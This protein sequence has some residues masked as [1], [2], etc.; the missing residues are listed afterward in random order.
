MTNKR[1][2]RPFVYDEEELRA[3][4]KR[5]DKWVE[6]DKNV[7]FGCFFEKEK[8]TQEH[9]MARGDEYDF[10]RESVEKAR[11]IQQARL[12]N[13]ALHK[14]LSDGMAK[15]CLINNHGWTEKTQISGDKANP[16]AIVLDE[17]DGSTKSLTE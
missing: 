1:M 17:I 12:I 10:I 11:G 3:I 13:G 8:I 14:R 7:W 5:L 16:L 4:C 9:F 2:G 6:D 15:F